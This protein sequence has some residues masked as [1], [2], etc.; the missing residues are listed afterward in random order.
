MCYWP[1]AVASWG[2]HLWFGMDCVLRMFCLSQL[3]LLPLAFLLVTVVA[4]CSGGAAPAKQASRRFAS[5]DAPCPDLGFS[6]RNL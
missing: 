2:I 6:W 5:A 3:R 1:R 4:G